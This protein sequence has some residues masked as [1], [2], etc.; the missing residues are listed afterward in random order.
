MLTKSRL[1][2]SYAMTV[3][4]KIQRWTDEAKMGGFNICGMNVDLHQGGAYRVAKAHSR[5]AGVS[6]AKNVIHHALR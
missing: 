2:F 1:F 5:N 4:D 3:M 6:E